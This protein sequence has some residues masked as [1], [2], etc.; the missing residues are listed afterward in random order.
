L[1]QDYQKYLDLDGKPEKGERKL[2]DDLVLVINS[3]LK[4]YFHK[5]LDHFVLYRIGLLEFAL[6]LSPYNFDI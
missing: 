6:E 1:H 5:K 4:P 3:I 2:A